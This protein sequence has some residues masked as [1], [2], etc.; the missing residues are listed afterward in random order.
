MHKALALMNQ[1]FQQ[2]CQQIL[3]HVNLMLDHK[4]L[5]AEDLLQV[6]GV[7][8][9]MAQEMWDPQILVFLVLAFLRLLQ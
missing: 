8:R 1:N 9:E 2:G 3:P 4:E 6:Y 7:V 5:T